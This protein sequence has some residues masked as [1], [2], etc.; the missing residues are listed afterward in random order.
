MEHLIYYERRMNWFLLLFDNIVKHSNAMH[1]I[2]PEHIKNTPYV[3]SMYTMQVHMIK[4]FKT[5][6]GFSY[7]E[8]YRIA[9]EE[10]PFY[11][12]WY[13]RTGDLTDPCGHND[14]PEGFQV[15]E[16]C[17]SCC[18]GETGSGWICCP[19]CKQWYHD[20]CYEK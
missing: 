9:T 12:H 18:L 13:R 17:A 8:F 20:E 14:L 1:S 16:T 5:K 10:K 15:D 4:S 6:A 11:T 19:L 2:E 3:E 7:L